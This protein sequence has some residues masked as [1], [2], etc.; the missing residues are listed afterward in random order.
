LWLGSCR[1]RCGFGRNWNHHEGRFIIYQ[2]RIVWLNIE[3]RNIHNYYFVSVSNDFFY[4]YCKLQTSLFNNTIHALH[5]LLYYLNQAAGLEVVADV[6]STQSILISNP[7]AEHGDLVDLIKRRIEGY[8]TATKYV[9][10]VY[11]ISSNLLE[12]A[13]R[14]TPGKRSPTVT[15]LDSAD[16]KSV[17][18]LV[19]KK[20]VNDRMDQ[21][22]LIGA[23]DILCLNISNSLM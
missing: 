6:L 18:S 2:I 9:M 3:C 7:Q 17:S 5:Q 4:T 12:E 10:I 20:E 14:I 22:H 23:T 1:C 11:N 13:I 15:S 21:L 16:C 8:I 19:L